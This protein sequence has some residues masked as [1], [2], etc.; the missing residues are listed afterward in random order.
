MREKFKKLKT[1]VENLTTQHMQEVFLNNK[2]QNKTEGIFVK[3]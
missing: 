1:K 2:F 3:I